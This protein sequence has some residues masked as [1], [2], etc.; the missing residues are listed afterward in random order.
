MSETK[1][2]S[3]RDHTQKKAEKTR[4]KM[5]LCSLYSVLCSAA[6]TSSRRR[7]KTLVCLHVCHNS[8]HVATNISFPVY[9][10]AK[11]TDMNRTRKILPYLRDRIS[12]MLVHVLIGLKS[13][14]GVNQQTRKRQ[15]R[16]EGSWCVS[17]DFLRAGVF[18]ARAA[19]AGDPLQTRC[20]QL[21]E[22]G[23]RHVV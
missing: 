2:A 7:T 22:C 16:A 11:N 13:A 18:G 20:R 10:T 15:R 4:R 9:S 8:M 6:P 3:E 14:H 19:C 21:Q 23:S 12:N 5:R 17:P 1:R